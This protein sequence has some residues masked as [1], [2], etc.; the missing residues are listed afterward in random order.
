MAARRRAQVQ[1]QGSS[2]CVLYVVD[3]DTNEVI[4]SS[5]FPIIDLNNKNGKFG[6]ARR[7]ASFAFYS[8]IDAIFSL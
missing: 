1:N 3:N 5:G 2:A 7:F 8:N 6:C 4:G